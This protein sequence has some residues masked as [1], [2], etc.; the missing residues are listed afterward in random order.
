ML[1]LSWL[2]RLLWLQHRRE[3]ASRRVVARLGR[4]VVSTTRRVVVALPSS[5]LLPPT[6]RLR[7]LLQPPASYRL[8][9]PARRHR[10]QSGAHRAW[11]RATRLK[12]P[13]ATAPVVP[14]TALAV[15]TTAR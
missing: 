2:H 4:V 12:R 11:G 15:P 7:R 14:T 5:L 13:P 8:P 9:A 3:L 10:R 6:C 1:R